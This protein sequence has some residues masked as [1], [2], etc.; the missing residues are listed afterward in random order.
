M[1]SKLS[2]GFSKHLLIFI[3]CT[4]VLL[5][6][7]QS[8]RSVVLVEIWYSVHLMTLACS[9]GFNQL[10]WVCQGNWKLLD[11]MARPQ[12]IEVR[13]SIV[14]IAW[15]LV[16]FGLIIQSINLSRLSV[17]SISFLLDL[18]DS[19]VVS[20][21]VVSLSERYLWSSFIVELFAVESSSSSIH[22]SSCFE[23]ALFIWKV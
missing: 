22:I 6:I 21:S 11:N 17:S 12:N 1:L 7:F 23:W 13:S 18:V 3:V 5:M 14:D 19:L 2:I 8:C 4:L 20:S 10:L 15:S 9:H 16:K